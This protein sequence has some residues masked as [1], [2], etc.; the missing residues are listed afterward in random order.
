MA[1]TVQ[2]NMERT[3]IFRDIIKIKDR[4]DQSAEVDKEFHEFITPKK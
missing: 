4:K 3:A 1:K 2:N